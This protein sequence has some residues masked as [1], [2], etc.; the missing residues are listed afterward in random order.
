MN[1]RFMIVTKVKQGVRSILPACVLS[2]HTNQ[3]VNVHMVQK[4]SRIRFPS[5]NFLLIRKRLSLKS[6]NHIHR[7]C[8]I[9]AELNRRW[10]RHHVLGFAKLFISFGIRNNWLISG[11]SVL[12]YVSRRM[13]K[14]IVVVMESNHSYQLHE[15]CYPAILLWRVIACVRMKLLGAISVVWGSSRLEKNCTLIIGIPRHNITRLTKC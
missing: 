6:W 8:L 5:F 9:P 3:S 1:N 2:K 15:I 12:L 7:S 11:R 14:L 4:S 10:V 13:I